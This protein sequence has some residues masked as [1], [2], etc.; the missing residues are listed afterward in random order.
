MLKL[1]F[2]EFIKQLNR[3]IGIFCL[4]LFLVFNL[5]TPIAWGESASF[6]VKVSNPAELKQLL[7]YSYKIVSSP[8]LYAYFNEVFKD[9]L[10][11][12]EELQKEFDLKSPFR[13]LSEPQLV[14]LLKNLPNF[15]SFHTFL[16]TYTERSLQ[17]NKNEPIVPTEGMEPVKEQLDKILE[18]PSVIE[19]LKALNDPSKTLTIDSLD[20]KAGFEGVSVHFNREAYLNHDRPNDGLVPAED[21][22]KIMIENLRD[23]KESISIN[24]FEFNLMEIADEIE[25]ALVR[26]VRVRIGI[27]RNTVR[28]AKENIDVLNKLIRLHRTYRGQMKLTLVKSAGLNHQK[29]VV[30]DSNTEN[31]KIVAGSANFTQS[32]MGPEGDAVKLAPDLRPKTSKPNSNH[33]FIIKSSFL[34]QIAEHELNKTLDHNLRGQTQYPISGSYTVKGSPVDGKI[35]ILGTGFSPNGG[36]GGVSSSLIN[37]WLLKSLGEVWGLQFVLSSKKVLDTLYKMANNFKNTFNFKF[38]GDTSFAMQRWSVP[39]LLS[40]LT[41]EEETKKYIVDQE[42]PLRKSLSVRKLKEQQE[43]IRL[44]PKEYGEF[45]YKIQNEQ[46]KITVKMHNKIIVLP[47]INLAFIGTSFNVS[48]SAEANQEQL[49][50]IKDHPIVNQV[51]NAFLYHF[52]QATTTV[53]KQSRRRNLFISSPDLVLPKKE[54]PTGAEKNHREMYDVSFLP[55]VD[56]SLKSCVRFYESLK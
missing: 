53:L 29:M 42:S 18:N 34:A 50:W 56:R 4:I 54:K 35:P 37:P 22:K 36:T 26:G 24:I 7:F 41:R 8:R 28:L 31:A 5:L 13:K 51:K 33:L 15:E 25:R 23:A 17:E 38:F 40:G 1:I 14:F 55:K 32:C 45:H 43:N 21:L 6:D 46:V 52:D 12:S 48:D 11:V 2:G 39:L 20:G 19:E 30:I 44:N 9:H 27:D 16:D 49:F 47:K 10:V 3:G